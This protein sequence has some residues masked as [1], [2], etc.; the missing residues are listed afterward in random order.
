[1]RALS[2]GL[3][4]GLP[5]TGWIEGGQLTADVKGVSN[6]QRRN[7]TAESRF[8]QLVFAKNLAPANVS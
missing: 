2:A 8:P 5:G 7:G 4:G 1:M 6:E 3:L